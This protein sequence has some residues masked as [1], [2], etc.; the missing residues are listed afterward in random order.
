MPIR[1]EYSDAGRGVTL[2]G[3]G[4]VTA[5][6]LLNANKEI[7]SRDLAAEPYDYGLFDSSGITAMPVSTDGMEALAN[8]VMA[9]S[10]KMHDFTI[11]IFANSDAVSTYGQIWQFLT[12]K[13]GWRSQIFRS[14]A[15]AI[16]WLKDEVTKKGRPFSLK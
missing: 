11:A 12:G 1:I 7:Y 9:V 15:D 16:A 2:I 6:D 13:S 10:G 4:V 8:R 14:R 5:D 3:E